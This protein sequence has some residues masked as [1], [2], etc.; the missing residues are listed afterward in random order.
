[1]AQDVIVCTK[2]HLAWYHNTGEGVLELRK[3]FPRVASRCNQ[4]Q[5]SHHDV[6]N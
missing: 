1:M 2:P 6:K 4:H 3:W 5:E